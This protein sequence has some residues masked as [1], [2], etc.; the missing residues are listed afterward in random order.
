MFQY[1]KEKIKSP[2]SPKPKQTP[3]S[4]YKK[5][6]AIIGAGISGMSA[7]YALSETHDVT[8]YES[9]DR[10][11]GHARTLLAGK[12]GN[13]P[14]DTGF[15]VFNY[16]N[17]PG[18][19]SLF[20]RLDV[21]VIKSNMGFAASIDGG[22]IEYSLKNLDSIFAQRLNCI[23]PRF[24]NMLM[25]IQRFNKTASSYA[26]KH[27]DWTLG[28][29]FDFMRMGKWFRNYYFL[30]ISGAIW[31]TPLDKMMEFPAKSLLSFFENHA[32][33]SASGQHQW[34]TVDGGS[35]E[36]VRRLEDALVSSGVKIRKKTPISFVRRFPVFVEIISSGMIEKFDEVVFA[37][38]S[39]TALNLLYHDADKDERSALSK[40]RY[41]PNE[42][43]LHSDITAM[44][45]RKKCWASWN[46]KTFSREEQEQIPLT[47][48]MNSL[49]QIPEE[50]PLFVTLNATKHIDPKKIYDMTTM[51][52]PVYDLD[53]NEG[54]RLLGT[55][56]GV[57]RTWFC[58]AYMKNG[59]HE[60]GFSSGLEVATLIKMSERN[61]T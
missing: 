30:P 51:Y 31:S 17:Y 43:V 57:N 15:I 32:L 37:T 1:L 39:N 33:L 4:P 45:K 20:E 38:H 59:F 14:V 58:G 24:L 23:D 60:D 19:T 10:L 55:R 44:P 11:G 18:L 13:Q 8:L 52:H 3:D 25:D 22:K 26:Q 28:Q 56:Q 54:R 16:K 48:W 29:L 46:Y 47:Y 9:E 41:Q 6:V 61:N 36:Y 42:V 21:P 27:D 40:L 7:A 50:D 53:S 5:K 12:K 35:I 49:Q 2:F 34:Y